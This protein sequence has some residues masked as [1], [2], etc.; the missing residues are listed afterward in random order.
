MSWLSITPFGSPVVPDCKIK[1]SQH[2]KCIK[3]FVTAISLQMIR[4][5]WNWFGCMART[6]NDKTAKQ[7]L[8]TARGV[9]SV[10]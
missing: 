5:K 10:T 7:V 9:I 8:E 2:D 3:T 4:M 1:N 6:A